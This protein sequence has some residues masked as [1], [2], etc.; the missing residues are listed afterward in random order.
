M[1]SEACPS[2]PHATPSYAWR[3]GPHIPRIGGEWPGLRGRAQGKDRKGAGSGFPHLLWSVS[4]LLCAMICP[5]LP[6]SA[7]PSLTFSPPLQHPGPG[8][9]AISSSLCSFC[10]VL[11]KCT[12]A[13][14]TPGPLL[15]CRNQVSWQFH[16]EGTCRDR[17]MSRLVAFALGKMAS[18]P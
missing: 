8:R 10:H 12:I 7:P 1:G 3:K 2:V 17:R 4:A 11:K 14:Y 5:H 13:G 6:F 18:F 16:G 9:A 15:V